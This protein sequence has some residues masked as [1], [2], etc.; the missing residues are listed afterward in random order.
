M[1][2][3]LRRPDR[4]ATPRRVFRQR[5]ALITGWL[6]IAVL[7]L[8]VGLSVFADHNLGAALPLIAGAGIAWVVLVRPAVELA[9]DGV[10]LRNLVRDVLISWPAVSMLEERW[11]LKV[12]T[13]DD[14]AF[15]SWAVSAQRPKGR[16]AGSA[17][18]GLGP[19]VLPTTSAP[20]AAGE[21]VAEHRAASAGAVASAIR[22]AKEDYERAV[23][24]GGIP[25][26]EARAV[27]RPAVA[28]L[29]V[30]ALAVVLIA[31]WFLR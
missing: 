16:M 11:N 26:Q 27:R 2:N 10:L 31:V 7:V 15:G 17:A 25:E 14:R 4:P 21:V 29:V 18:G 23:S 19:R 9:P 22:A 5:G 20:G 1:P 3:P 24:S 12:V 13:P 28:P 8:F 30:L 6:L